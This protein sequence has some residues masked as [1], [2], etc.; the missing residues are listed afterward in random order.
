M[1]TPLRVTF[2]TNTYS[3]VG[4][5]QIDRIFSKLWPF[6]RTR[7]RSMRDRACWWYLNWCIRRGRIIAAIPEPTLKAEVLPNVQRVSALLAVGTQA[8]ATAPPIPPTRHDIIQAAFNTGFL[9]LRSPRIG[10][11]SLYPVPPDRWAP[12]ILHSQ[13]ERHDRESVFVRHFN[14]YPLEAVK[15]FGERLSKAHGLGALPQNA[16]RVALASYNNM[17]VDRFLWRQGLAAE[18]AKPV[19][20]GSVGAFQKELRNLLAD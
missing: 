4:R 14:N 5:P 1:K 15:D 2:D 6:D 19:A 8:A 16:H 18:E 9:V 20:T 7:F 3:A 12:D 10:W 17:T 11:G 13:S